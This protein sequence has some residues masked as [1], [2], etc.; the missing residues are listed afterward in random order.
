V[1]AKSKT[2]SAESFIPPKFNLSTLK[3]S[4]A[5]C[6]ACPLYKSGTQTVFGEG[7]AK[8]RI[9]MVGEQPGND[10]DLMGRPFV[11]PAG[12]RMEKALEEAGL[13]R[14]EVYLTNAVKHFKWRPKADKRIHEKPNVKEIGACKPWLK[15]ELFLLKPDILV[16]LGSTA[17]QAVLGRKVKIK[18]ERGK[19][20]ETPWAPSTYITVHPSSL[21][22]HPEQEQR[23][24]AYREFVSDMRRIARRYRSAPRRPSKASMEK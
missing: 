9:M 7:P 8:A 3:S 5:S 12:R 15:A 21:L 20:F 19:F 16:C 22:R 18:D 1:P 10:E 24:R 17:A 13:H 23:R 14:R 6:T 4:A 11:G 2:Q